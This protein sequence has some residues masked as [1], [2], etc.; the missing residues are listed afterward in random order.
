MKTLILFLSLLLAASGYAAP[1]TNTVTFNWLDFGYQVDSVTNKAVKI[2]PLEYSTI[3]SFFMVK[4]PRIYTNTTAGVC[5]VTNMQAGSYRVELPTALGSITV[6]TSTVP[7]TAT[8]SSNYDATA[9]VTN[10]ATNSG[11]TRSYSITVSDLRYPS[12]AGTNI[13]FYTNAGRITIAG[14]TV[15]GTSPTVASN[16]LWATKLDTTNANIALTTNGITITSSN[17]SSGL[18]IT[19]NGTHVSGIGGSLLTFDTPIVASSDA[20]HFRNQGNLKFALSGGNG[21]FTLWNGAYSGGGSQNILYYTDGGSPYLQLGDATKPLDVYFEKNMICEGAGAFYGNGSG[22][23][24]VG[25]NA[26]IETL[27]VMPDTQSA[28]S[29]GNS[30]VLSLQ[31]TYIITNSTNLNITMV[32]GVGDIVDDPTALQQWTNAASR[33]YY[34]LKTNGLAHIAAIGNHDYNVNG[35]GADRASTV[36]DGYFG[37]NYYSTQSWFTGGF[38]TNGSSRNMYAVKKFGGRDTLF[39]SLE[40]GMPTNVLNWASGIIS[41]SYPNHAIIITTHAYL[42]NDGS[43]SGDRPNQSF[44]PTSYTP[45]DSN[46]GNMAWNYAL[47]KWRNLRLI[48]CGHYLSNGLGRKA[49]VG[50]FGNVVHSVLANYQ[51]G[52]DEGALPSN[53]Y[54]RFMALDPSKNQINVTTYSPFQVTNNPAYAYLTDP[55]NQFGFPYISDVVVKTVSPDGFSLLPVSYTNAAISSTTATNYSVVPGEHYIIYGQNTNASFTFFKTNAGAS[56]RL[57]I[58]NLTSTVP[59]RLSFPSGVLTNFNAN[60]IVTNGWLQA[61]SVDWLDNTGTNVLITVGDRYGR[62]P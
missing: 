49:Q 1:N 15:S 58:N 16:F 7:S 56:S 39:F 5:I 30:N 47:K 25:Q 43:V 14:T 62:Q 57:I 61:V 48:V 11:S 26:S 37:T 53:G 33:L 42:H 22:L 3:G 28:A 17:I 41:N 34:P 8:G 38:F 21:T 50:D 23:T 29:L 9:F 18:L 19:N 31:S 36:Y 6:F 32:L 12:V 35:V 52:T 59:C 24:N 46:N 27:V 54:M 4:T 10:Y 40:F 44:N 2:T 45:T 60:L 55:E 13:V 51:V 20:I